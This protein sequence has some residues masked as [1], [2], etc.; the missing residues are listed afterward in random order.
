MNT[1][2]KIEILHDYEILF[3]FSDGVEKIIDFAAFIG[4]DELTRPLRNREYF[5]KIRIYENGRGVYWPNDYDACPD[6]IRNYQNE[7][8]S[9]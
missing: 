7:M 4:D 6:F 8:S 2:K 5:K 1:I 3:C 9:Q